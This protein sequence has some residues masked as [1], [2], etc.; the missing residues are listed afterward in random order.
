[1]TLIEFYADMIP[2]FSF[3]ISILCSSDVTE[4]M[5]AVSVTCQYSTMIFRGY[6]VYMQNVM[7]MSPAFVESTESGSAVNISSTGAG[8]HL[9]YVFPVWQT[10][11]RIPD[12][13]LEPAHRVVYTL[14]GK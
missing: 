7:D 13:R 2:L 12:G 5:S 14:T 4:D 8:E 11:S 1:M 10:N 9:V 6:G 3:G